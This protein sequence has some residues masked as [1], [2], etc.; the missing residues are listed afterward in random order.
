MEAIETTQYNLQNP[1]LD[2]SFKRLDKKAM[3]L[4]EEPR[5]LSQVIEKT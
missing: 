3:E 1:E 4:F 2:L 5:A